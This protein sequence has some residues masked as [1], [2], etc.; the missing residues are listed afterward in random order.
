MSSVPRQ[1]HV[2]SA[3]C[4]SHARYTLC[5]HVVCPT[6]GIRYVSMLSVPRQVYVMSASCLSHARY[7]LCQH[8]VCPTPDTRYV[9]MLSV[10]RQTR[11]VS[12]LSVPRQVHVMSSNS[13]NQQE[14]LCR[15]LLISVRFFYVLY[16][17]VCLFAF[18]FLC[19]IYKTRK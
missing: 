4:L 17:L 6:P 16:L 11:Y 9:S 14:N 12:M 3:C 8:V 1:V 10:P 19:K 18:S 15:R 5:Q 2:M 7:T 13:V